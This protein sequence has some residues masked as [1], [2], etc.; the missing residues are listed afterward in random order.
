[1]AASSGDVAEDADV[2]AEDAGELFAS[3]G[4]FA[5]PAGEV[6]HHADVGRAEVEVLGGEFDGVV[7]PAVVAGPVD[8]PAEVVGDLAVAD[9]VQGVDGPGGHGD[10]EE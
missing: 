4:L 5:E 7:G 6:G 10:D 8:L 1:M 9:D 2:Q 3:L